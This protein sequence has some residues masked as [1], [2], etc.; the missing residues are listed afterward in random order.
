LIYLRG[1]SYGNCYL[2]LDFE[3]S[4]ASTNDWDDP[5]NT[6]DENNPNEVRDGMLLIDRCGCGLF[7]SSELPDGRYA[8][9]H[10]GYCSRYQYRCGTCRCVPASL[11]VI[12]RIEGI[13]F[14]TVAT[15]NGTDG[16]EVTLSESITLRMRITGGPKCPPNRTG[17]DDG[18][19]ISVDNALTEYPFDPPLDES[20]EIE[21]GKFMTFE[22]VSDFEEDSTD[23]NWV[24]GTASLCGCA[25]SICGPCVEERCGGPPAVLYADLQ[26]IGI[27]RMDNPLVYESECNLTVPMYYWQRWMLPITDPPVMLCGWIGYANITCPEGSQSPGDA[28]IRVEWSPQETGVLKVTRFQDGVTQE[29][30]V[31]LEQVSCDPFV[32]SYDSGAFGI[33]EACLWGCDWVTEFTVG[34]YE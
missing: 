12:G 30:E 29:K 11:C 6:F 19:V 27:P 17:R 7:I 4:G 1:D 14:S 10:G 33:N 31:V 25:N 26:A 32:Y 18:C 28:L 21:C 22:A 3:Q 24:W 2:E 8:R 16:W 20:L 9:I 23:F 13:E 15:W 34:V 5:P